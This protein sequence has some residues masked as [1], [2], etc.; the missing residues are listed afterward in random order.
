MVDVHL[1]ADE[2]VRV[3]EE[4]GAAL[5][6]SRAY[7]S[8][9][10]TAIGAAFK[11]AGLDER[12]ETLSV[13]PEAAERLAEQITEASL[14]AGQ[15]EKTA[16]SYAASWR[17]LSTIAL[18]WKEAGGDQPGSTFWSESDLGDKRRRRLGL[19][20]PTTWGFTSAEGPESNS[21]DLHTIDIDLPAGRATLT[22]PNG[23]TD[24]D[25]LEIVRTILDDTR[26][27]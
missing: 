17:R 16:T 21:P 8:V 7:Q 3:L 11:T 13:S 20:Q 6:W 4:A 27:S 1:T 24:A 9:I 26:S 12:Q 10:G 23:V 14:A 22:L 18:Q 15:A 19:R 2:L 5:G 25:L